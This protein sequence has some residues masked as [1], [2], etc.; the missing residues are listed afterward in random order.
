VL[1]FRETNLFTRQVVEKLSDLDYTEL[2]AALMLQPEL[3]DLIQGT[4]GLRKLRWAE[5]AKG[6]GKRGGVRI[7]YYWFSPQALIY[8]LLM[9]SKNERD[10]LS[11]AEKAKLRK[12]IAQE[13]K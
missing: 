11:A 6:K 8:M 2:Q 1:T 10:D 7:I 13:F 9:Y 4:G 5:S 3:G 12:L